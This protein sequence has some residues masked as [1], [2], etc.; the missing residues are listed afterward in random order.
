MKSYIYREYGRLFAA[1]ELNTNLQ[2]RA[3]IESAHTQD[4]VSEH[5]YTMYIPAIFN[6]TEKIYLYNVGII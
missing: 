4:R 3:D 2:S 1:R 5:I 6:S